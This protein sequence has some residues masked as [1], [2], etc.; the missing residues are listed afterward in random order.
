MKEEFYKKCKSFLSKWSKV[1][2]TET[3]KKLHNML[4]EAA[5]LLSQVY[6][7]PYTVTQVD[8]MGV[9][10]KHFDT[11]KEARAY[12]FDDAILDAEEIWGDHDDPDYTKSVREAI[13]KEARAEFIK[14]G[15]LDG[16]LGAMYIEVEFYLD[17]VEANDEITAIDARYKGLD[18]FSIITRE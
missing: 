6:Q 1:T 13:I 18:T 3:A 11:L 9:Y 14:T 2:G 17:T 5:E 12:V 15:N 16:E 4:A 7:K 8:E 10:V